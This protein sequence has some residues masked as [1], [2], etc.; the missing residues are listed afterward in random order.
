M[1]WV[2]AVSSDADCERAARIASEEVI[3]QLDGQPPDLVFFCIR[4]AP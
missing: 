1:Q 2:S 3:D 4:G